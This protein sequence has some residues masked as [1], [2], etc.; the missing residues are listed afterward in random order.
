MPPIRKKSFAAE[1]L[2]RQKKTSPV[3]WVL[4]VIVV[5]ALVVGGY[6]MYQRSVQ[7]KAETETPKIKSIAVLPFKDLSPDKDQE[8]FCDGLADEIINDLQHIGS[9]R[10]IA[11]TSSFAYKGQDKDVREIGKELEVDA[12]FEGSVT[13]YG[14]RLRIIAQL[15]NVTDGSHFFS[16]PY[17]YEMAD[18][19]DI[20]IDLSKKIVETLKITILSEEQAAIEKQYTDNIEAHDLYLLGR[21]YYRLRSAEGH[22][23]ALNYYKQAIEKDPNFALAYVGIADL[24]QTS[25]VKRFLPSRKIESEKIRELIVKALDIDNTLAEAY[26]TSAW[27]SLRDLEFSEA[28]QGFEKALELKPG[29]AQAHQWYHD[30]YLTIGKKDKAFSEILRAQELDPLS[31]L[32]SSIIMRNFYIQGKV[33]K[34][35]EQFDKTVNLDPNYGMN[36]IWVSEIYEDQGK[37]KDAVDAYSIGA[38]LV[39]INPSAVEEQLGYLYAMTGEKDKAKNILNKLLKRSPVPLYNIARIYLGLDERGK[40]ELVLKKMIEH[41]AAGTVP[42]Y[43]IAVIY[44]KMDNID[45]SL[46][47]LEKNIEEGLFSAFYITIGSFWEPLRSDPRYNDLLKKMNIPKD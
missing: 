44:M 31:P 40:A 1:Q 39:G 9:L 20:R 37:Y 45:K 47:W 3:V 43:Y 18:L 41:N 28:K 27:N 5:V 42:S 13:K 23:K 24:Y 35:M 38:E 8:W 33:D 19:L 26:V 4:A 34:A 16:E 25:W 46:E 6:V 29:N 32:I 30:Y 15:V 36:Y 10:I 14:S 7:E 12:I 11:S 22:E 17:T 21:Q 2:A